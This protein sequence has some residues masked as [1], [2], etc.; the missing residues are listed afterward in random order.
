MR[1][2]TDNVD[3]PTTCGTDKL[4][5]PLGAK[6]NY[7]D[8]PASA[9]PGQCRQSQRHRKSVHV[10][11]CLYVDVYVH[12]SAYCCMFSRERQRG[13]KRH[14]PRLHMHDTPTH[15]DPHPESRD[16]H[17][18]RSAQPFTRLSAMCAP[19]C[20]ALHSAVLAFFETGSCMTGSSFSFFSVF[21]FS[22]G[23]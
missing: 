16:V 3:T 18:R 17:A 20:G 10:G 21:F 9:K 11:I 8:K 2:L 12:R 22:S 15:G 5:R 6:M 7:A 1:C 23:M 19:I 4:Q 14:D 13:G